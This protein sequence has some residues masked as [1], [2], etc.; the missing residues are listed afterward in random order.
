[1]AT[2]MIKVMRPTD[3]SLD[4][5]STEIV[6][7]SS[8]GL[9]GDDMRAL[10]KRAGHEFAE[11]CKN[12]KVARDET[13]L[14]L[15]AL[16][17]TEAYGP[18]RNGDGFSEDTCKKFHDTFVKHARWYRNH[19][20]KDQAKSYGYIKASAYNERM[21]R[22]E[23]LVMLNATKEAAARNGG[24]VADKE[25]EKLA[26]KQ[27]I[28]VSMACR[29]PFDKCASCGN[30]AKNRSEYCTEESCVGPHGEKRGGCRFNLTKV[31]DDGFINHVDNP[32]ARWFDM[33]DVPK[34]ADRTA[35]AFPADYLQKAASG[36][37]AGGAELAE[38][39]GITAP[40]GL[41]LGGG[42]TPAVERAIKLAYDVAELERG[43]LLS[44]G[45]VSSFAPDV[46]S[47]ADLTGL[48]G[49]RETV[50]TALAALAENKIVL[51]VR[52]FLRWQ[53]GD[54]NEKLAG[55]TAQV[56]LRLPGIFGRLVADP[57]LETLVKTSG[58]FAAATTS[59]KQ[60]YWAEKQASALSLGR[61]HVEE[62]AYRAGL[63]GATPSLLSKIASPAKT[64][65]DEQAES[66]A[67]QYAVYKLAFL[68]T[69]SATDPELPLT[70]Q[71]VILQN[72]AI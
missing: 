24:L 12:I 20:N 29:V 43:A 18:N 56:L 2:G 65:T 13:A 68:S 72:H 59:P 7:Y 53:M 36:Y 1:M 28:A 67:R 71:L 51:N 60:R 17:A 8:H 46:Q 33:S 31:A 70:C 11:A 41:M 9:V 26:R 27:D 66:L 4:T 30:E 15:I 22:I 69:I 52:D 35:F 6:K 48:R 21:K 10:V 40:F 44:G 37:V 47:D 5:A 3:W 61:R 49:Q 64:A 55:L 42:L 50:K 23:L 32:G 57:N 58:Y 25:L 63:Y 39:L 38:M 54:D 14:H 62:R 16:G 19:Q 34:G 45:Y